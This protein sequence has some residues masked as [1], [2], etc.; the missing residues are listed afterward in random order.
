MKK[1]SLSFLLLNLLI[2]FLN[3]EIYSK[4]ITKKQKFDLN[5]NS[6]F[7]AKKFDVV[8]ISRRN[9]EK[10]LKILKK[11]DYENRPRKLIINGKISYKYKK[12]QNEPEKSINELENIINNPE[13]TYKYESFIEN[14]LI[15]LLD[16][17]VKL[18]IKDFNGNLS[19]Q[20]DHKNKSIFIDKDVFK[21]G[22]KRFAYLLSHEII[23]VS[24]SCKGGG[25]SSYPVL[26]GLKIKKPKSF[27]SGNLEN[28]FYRDLKDN[29]VMLEVEAYANEK[30]IYQ[31]LKVFR[32]FC[33]NQK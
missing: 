30:N 1:K 7:I 26:I 2:F 15:Y 16:L 11:Y 32:Y 20:W 24:Q 33:L 4:L 14:S 17:G 27:Y 29:E 21:E 3:V 8:K 22:T 19:G 13:K 12:L 28:S 23:H 6:K 18:K 31:T 5:Q 25:I 10:I 9:I